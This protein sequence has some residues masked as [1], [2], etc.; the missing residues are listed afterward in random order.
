MDMYVLNEYKYT[1]S[2]LQTYTAN[3]SED[4]VLQKCAW[5]LLTDQTEHLKE[6]NKEPLQRQEGSA[7][8]RQIKC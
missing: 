3:H 2:V 6:G 7:G 8:R 4:V 1:E 5:R